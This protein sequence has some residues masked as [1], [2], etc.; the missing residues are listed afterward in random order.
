MASIIL[1]WYHLIIPLAT[2]ASSGLN[3]AEAIY[4]ILKGE[5]VDDTYVPK[6][7]QLLYGAFLT[8]NRSVK[9]FEKIP[10]KEHYIITFEDCNYGGFYFHI[11]PDEMWWEVHF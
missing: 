2:T 6:A 10:L 11:T 4:Y 7:M 8:E 5:D 1:S 9:K 3:T